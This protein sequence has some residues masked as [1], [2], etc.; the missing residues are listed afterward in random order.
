[1]SLSWQQRESRLVTVVNAPCAIISPSCLL[2][3]FP[4]ADRLQ[5]T[6]LGTSAHRASATFMKRFR[7]VMIRLYPFVRLG[8]RTVVG[9]FLFHGSCIDVST[10]SSQPPSPGLVQCEL[11]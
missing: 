6:A 4:V 10:G 7:S 11:S 8:V 1:M 5:R 3:G 2:R 9:M